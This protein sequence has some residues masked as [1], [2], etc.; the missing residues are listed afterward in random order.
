[1]LFKILCTFVFISCPRRTLRTELPRQNKALFLYKTK[2][3][4]RLWINDRWAIH[5][6]LIIKLTH[7]EAQPY[8]FCR[9]AWRIVTN[10][11]RITRV[12]HLLTYTRNIYLIWVLWRDLTTEQMWRPFK[13]K[14]L[15]VKNTR[16]NGYF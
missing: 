15:R 1:M 5:R 14:E 11:L 3:S 4:I 9:G 13:Q 2:K 10:Y 7:S 6:K 8:K 16:N 12:L